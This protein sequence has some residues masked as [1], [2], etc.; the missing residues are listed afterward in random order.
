[1][2]LPLPFGRGVIVCAETIPVPRNGAEAALPAIE[3]ALTAAAEAARRA[4]G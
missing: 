1:M 4:C 2:V 3:A